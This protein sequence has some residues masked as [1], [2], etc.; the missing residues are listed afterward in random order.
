MTLGRPLVSGCQS[1]T[2]APIGLGGSRW[3][4]R[5]GRANRWKTRPTEA[6][7]FCEGCSLAGTNRPP[8]GLASGDAGTA[9]ALLRV[10]H[11]RGKRNRRRV[12]RSIST[13]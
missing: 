13:V 1:S 5:A 9:V 11:D 12:I 7:R 3:G 8:Q 2:V 4:D 10:R 6:I